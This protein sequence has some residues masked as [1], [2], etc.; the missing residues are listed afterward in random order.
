MEQRPVKTKAEG[1]YPSP[2]AIFMKIKHGHKTRKKI[3]AT[4]QTWKNMKA[5]CYNSNRDNYE[6]YGARGIKVCDNWFNSFENFLSDMGERPY[7]MTL[8][9]KD[10]NG[11]YNLENCRWAT[12]QEQGINK[13]KR[14]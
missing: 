4:Y 5:R 8:D 14:K 7:G 12:T 2:T 13:R 9:R 11:N 10:P 6:Y 3:S 1:S